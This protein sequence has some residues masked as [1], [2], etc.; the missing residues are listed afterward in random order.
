ML[1]AAYLQKGLQREARAALEEALRLCQNESR[2]EGFLVLSIEAMLS[3]IPPLV[4]A[5]PTP[6]P[7]EKFKPPVP[8]TPAD[9]TVKLDNSKLDTAQVWNVPPGGYELVVTREGYKRPVK[10]VIVSHDRCHSRR[11]PRI[12]KEIQAQFQ[13]TPADR[14]I[15]FGKSQLGTAPVMELPV[16][17]YELVV[18]HE[19]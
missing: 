12:G 15:K 4:P 14:P 6:A 13:A 18:T 9:H 5:P 16:G 17:R 1:G 8:A 2:R 7:P 3:Y 10:Q 11:R 19:G